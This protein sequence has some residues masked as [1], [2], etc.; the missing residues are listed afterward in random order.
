M[1]NTA[2]LGSISVSQIPPWILSLP[3]LEIHKNTLVIVDLY[4]AM[5]RHAKCSSVIETVKIHVYVDLEV[6]DKITSDFLIKF[7]NFV[8]LKFIH[9]TDL[10]ELFY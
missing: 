7:S 3:F 6:S 4:C 8:F 10:E 2:I 5:R 1:L 9:P